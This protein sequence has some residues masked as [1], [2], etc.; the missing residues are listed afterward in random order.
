MMSM[1]ALNELVTKTLIIETSDGSSSS[2]S[3]PARNAAAV[4]TN[5]DKNDAGEDATATAESAGA[6]VG[7][8]GS[9]S[10]SSSSA[11][12]PAKGA[13]RTEI[14]LIFVSGAIYGPRHDVN[15]KRALCRF[16][17][18]DAL[19]AI[20]NVKFVKTGKSPNI[21]TATERL[22][23]D[24]LLPYAERGDG[25]G[26]RDKFLYTE[27]CDIALRRILPQL[28]RMYKAFSGRENTPLEEK[29][30]S[31]REWTD[32]CEMG[33]LDEDNLSERHM[34]L[35]YVH[36]LFPFMDVFDETLDFKKMGKF[37]F[38]E[39]IVR[40][41]YAMHKANLLQQYAEQQEALAAGNG[42]GVGGE[43]SIETITGGG[44]GVV[45]GAVGDSMS[46]LSAPDLQNSSVVSNTTTAAAAGGTGGGG[47]NKS[48]LQAT[49][50]VISSCVPEISSTKEF[51]YALDLIASKRAIQGIKR[52]KK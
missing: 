9:S 15:S 2:I 4:S 48:S 16:Q 29:T 17:F 26:F 6:S 20:A 27:E 30:M 3:G 23:V 18:L 37:E 39:C 11:S 14:E 44:V 19:V 13:T 33:A 32:L 1:A 22:I 36:S 51:G 34:K 7:A 21:V 31:F 5:A 45:P 28:E 40:S 52:G 10:S 8:A 49:N 46:A 38:F 42:G 25:K 43:S 47:M 35:A 24:H 50:S 12:A 41:G